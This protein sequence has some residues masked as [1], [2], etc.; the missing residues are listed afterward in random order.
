M[1][2]GKHRRGLVHRGPPPSNDVHSEINVT[3]LVDVCLVLLII[4]MVIMPSLMRGKE[5][6][7]PMTKHHTSEKDKHQPIV[8]IDQEGKIYF[9]KEVVAHLVPARAAMGASGELPAWTVDDDSVLRRQLEKQWQELAKRQAERLAKGVTDAEEA[10]AVGRK[11][12]VKAHPELTYGK[13]YPV[14]M[15]IHEIGADAIDL[16]THEQKH[17]AA[18]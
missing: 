17:E 8:A 7:L 1:A 13:V 5:I 10:E 6:K 18:P 15:A 14:V 9:D 3:P 16:G 4:F 12:F 11:V 2:H